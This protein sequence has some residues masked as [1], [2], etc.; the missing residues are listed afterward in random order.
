MGFGLLH[1][2]V[3]RWYKRASSARK[4]TLERKQKENE[5]RAAAVTDAPKAPPTLVNRLQQ[6]K[7]AHDKNLLTEEQFRA[8]VQTAVNSV[9]L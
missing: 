5:K 4:A 7:D 3:Q 2:D 1:C 8:A 6:L 9:T